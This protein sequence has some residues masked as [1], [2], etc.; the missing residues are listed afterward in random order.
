MEYKKILQNKEKNDIPI[1][2][3][4]LCD[5][6]RQISHNEYENNEF[7]FKEIIGIHLDTSELN[8]QFTNDEIKKCNSKLKQTDQTKE[9]VGSTL[10]YK[11][12]SNTTN[13]I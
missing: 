1:L 10:Y 2:I 11:L 12:R 7:S 5:H 8:C 3:N 13:N 9:S 4:Q 6:F